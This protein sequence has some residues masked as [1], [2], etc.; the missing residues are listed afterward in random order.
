MIK[1]D[2]HISW[3]CEISNITAT[4]V[5]KNYKHKYSLKSKLHDMESTS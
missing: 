4:E 2:F 1:H 3:L 5:T